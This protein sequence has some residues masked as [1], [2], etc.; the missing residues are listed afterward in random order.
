M[1][2]KYIGLVTAF[3]FLIVLAFNWGKTRRENNFRSAAVLG[4]IVVVLLWVYILLT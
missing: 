4:W 2:I 3:I 1:I